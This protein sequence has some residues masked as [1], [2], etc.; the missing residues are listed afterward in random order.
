MAGRPVNP[1]SDRCTSGR[2]RGAAAVEFALI[3]MLL[4]TLFVGVIEGGR[5]FVMQA[6][7]A[8]AA[9]EAARELAISNSVGNATTRA[10]TTFF[11]GTPIAA[12]MD[13]CPTPPV[14]GTNARVVL[15]FEPG[16]LTGLIPVN[17]TLRGTGV[18]RCG[19]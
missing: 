8:S 11:F 15:T 12:T 4:F 10:N 18:M 1:P 7:L 13:D 14:T 2:D 9:R 16:M 3:A 6:Q 17:V 19:G 5:L